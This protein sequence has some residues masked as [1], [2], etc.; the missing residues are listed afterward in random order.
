MTEGG[1]RLLKRDERVA[2]SL[3]AAARLFARDGF[4]ATTMDAIAEASGVTRPLL[5]R[6]FS[7]KRALYEAVLERVRFRLRALAEPLS[8]EE[9]LPGRPELVRVLLRA[10]RED[11][12]GFLLLFREAAGEP[13]FAAYARDH[14]ERLTRRAE[15]RLEGRIP[16]P[17]ERRVLARAALRATVEAVVA[18]LEE[19]D[20]RRDDEFV[21]ATGDALSGFAQ[22]TLAGVR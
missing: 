15:E 12:D 17:L 1:R 13:R 11:P 2:E 7:G 10:G 4:E 16:D 20:P 14:F 22:G 21:Q 3:R 19:G 18:W 9:R 6:H 5:Y 8:D